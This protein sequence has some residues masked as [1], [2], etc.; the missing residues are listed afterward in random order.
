MVYVEAVAALCED[1]VVWR[2]DGV[3]LIKSRTNPAV[4]I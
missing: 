4:Y 3:P 1:R 2:E